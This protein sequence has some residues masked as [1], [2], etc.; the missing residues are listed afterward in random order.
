MSLARSTICIAED[1]SAHEPS[2]KILLLSLISHCPRADIN[3]FYPASDEKFRAWVQKYPRVR[4]Q[5]TDLARGTG[6]N[7]KPQAILRLLDQGYD[8]VIWI[9]SDVIVTRDITPI[10]SNLDSQIFLASDTSFE[11]ERWDPNAL[12]ARSW[13]L[14]VGRMFPYA[15]NSGVLRVTKDH[16]LLME[17]WWEL[18]QSKQYQEAQ[19]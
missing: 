12:R 5:T 14:S 13:G 10:Y 4:L 15:L 7:V 1:R 17:R 6:W 8:E 3:L 19:K 11:R 9:D 2:V 18:V 16:R